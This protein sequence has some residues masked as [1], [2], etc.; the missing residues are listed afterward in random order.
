M[1][2]LRQVVLV[3]WTLTVFE[4]APVFAFEMKAGVAKAKIT[5]TEPLVMVNGNKVEG[6]AEDIYARALVLDDG[7]TPFVIITYDLNCL[8]VGTAILRQR[9]RDELGIP[10]ERLVL[11][12]THNHNAPIQIVPDNF[13][14]GRFLAD[15]MFD[16]IKEA[17]ANLV[18]PVKV[19]FGYGDGYFVTS[20]GNSPTD[21]EIQ[22][23]KVTHEGK[24]LALLF[25]HGTHP[26][27][28]SAKKIDAGHPGY[29]MDYIEE[30][31]PG[32]QAM[33]CDAS[34]GNQFV[35]RPPGSQQAAIKA[36]QEGPEALD[37]LLAE[38]ARRLGRE[39]AEVTLRIA[40][41]PLQDVTGPIRSVK[42]NLDLPL[43]DP[44]P[45]E[46][47][48]KL[49]TRVP[50]GTGFVPYPND[51]R[52]TNWVRMLEYWYENKIPFPKS[53]SELVCTD[54]TYF[55]H[56][57]DKKML[58]KYDYS[59]HDDLPGEYEEVIAATIGPMV[60]VA[61]QGEVCAPIGMRIKDA[62]RRDRPIFCTAYMGEHNLYIP[63]RELVRLKAYQAR[64]IQIQ[65]ASPV[66]WSPDVEDEMVN[67]VIG[68]VEDLI[69]SE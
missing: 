57:T 31:I 65:Y 5:T 42:K 24:P 18:G 35:I 26:A 20:R 53:L 30:A 11:L 56:K 25:N 54:D 32:V 66:E 33:Y 21:H 34:G 10:I 60:F 13:E 8:D 48:R 52:G 62:F 2:K 47:A 29:A 63:T 1:M 49:A 40:D 27:Q 55:I 61:M 23:L 46:E 51:Y 16:L 38:N 12:A 64:V 28:A 68:M 9:A 39:L 4:T 19:E 58:K 59:L 36:R 69:A 45:L 67:G 41:R 22:L 50:E 37:R 3:M 14:Y 17:Q 15:T 44:I 7:T 6:V 43:A